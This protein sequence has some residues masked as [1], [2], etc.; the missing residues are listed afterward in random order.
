MSRFSAGVLL[1]VL[2]A[3]P[4]L[5][6]DLLVPVAS[7]QKVLGNV[8]TSTKIWVSNPTTA[9]LS[10]TTRFY[11]AG[12]DGT[13]AGPVSSQIVVGPNATVVL[14]NVAPVGTSGMLGIAGGAQLAVGAQLISNVGGQGVGLSEVPSI[15]AATALTANA[16]AQLPGL[17]RVAAVSVSDAFL[18]NLE[19]S[20]AR[21]IIKVYQASGAQL[22]TTATVSLLPLERLDFVDTINGLALGSLTDLRVQASCDHKFWLAGLVRRASGE[23]GFVAPA[24]TLAAG[25]LNGGGGDPPPSGDT[26]TFTVPG[27]FLNA[28]DGNSSKSF[29]LPVKQGQLYKTTVIEYDLGIG[30]FPDGLFTGVQALRRPGTRTLFYGLQIV[31]R[32]GKTTLDL[33]VQ[34][35]LARGD[36]PWQEFH[37]YHMK[38]TYDVPNRRVTLEVFENGVRKQTLSGQAQHLDLIN[39]GHGLTIDFGQN[40]IADGAYYPPIG[41]KYSNLKVVLTP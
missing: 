30:R 39:D 23:I 16:V 41:W 33:G 22:A 20:A 11:P 4:V 9:A 1:A 21:C 15:S 13:K 28:V 35:I 36:G 32:N 18:F 38:I 2:S 17:E 31:N 14:A 12:T 24:S 27:L 25:L 10:F 34:D 6:G 19:A 7:N 8:S 5:A 3:G 26:V 37:L 29:P 40:G